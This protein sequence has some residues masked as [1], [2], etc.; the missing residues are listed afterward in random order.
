MFL[1][2]FESGFRRRIRERYDKTKSWNRKRID[3]LWDLLLVSRRRNEVNLKS[4]TLLPGG[5][6]VSF[7]QSRGFGTFHA[8]DTYFVDRVLHLAQSKRSQ[9]MSGLVEKAN[10]KEYLQQIFDLSMVNEENIFFLEGIL[11][12]EIIHSISEYFGDKLP[13]LHEASI[14]YSPPKEQENQSLKGSQL[15]HRDGEGTKNLKIWILCDDTSP[16][17]GPTVLLDALTSDLIAK[18]INYTPGEKITDNVIEKTISFE[19]SEK[20]IAVGRAGTSFYTDTC[21]SFHYGSRTTTSSSRLVAMYH[22]VDNNCS[23][24]FPYISRTFVSR[25][26]PLSIDVKNWS[27]ENPMAQAVLSKRLACS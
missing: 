19:G 9:V 2:K 23:Y 6:G 20:F 11:K 16:E 4:K 8:L 12:P 26:K 5:N 18:E 17:N 10:S 22:F 21:R 7:D 24:Y 27:K 15:F 13:L 14:F 25:L 1:T 3:S